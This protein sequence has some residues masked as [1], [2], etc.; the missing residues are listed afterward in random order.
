MRV[1]IIVEG[2]V[3][4]Y[5]CERCGIRRLDAATFFAEHGGRDLQREFGRG[6]REIGLRER[7]DGGEQPADRDQGAQHQSVSLR[8]ASKRREISH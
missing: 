2:P 8:F 7:R 1:E 6:T 4:R 3:Q 5:R